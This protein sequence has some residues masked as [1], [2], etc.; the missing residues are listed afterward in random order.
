MRA[1]LALLA[2]GVLLLVA[3]AAP[4]TAVARGFLPGAEGFEVAVTKAGGVAA[5]AAGSH[6]YALEATVALNSSP[7]ALRELEISL[8]PGFLINPGAVSECTD[9]A[10]HTARSTQKPGSLSG[11]SC[12]NTTQVGVIRV[13]VGGTV[14]YFGLFNLV[15]PFGSPL[16]I[17]A[18]P[19]GTP[20]VFAGRLR[21]DDYGLD[22]VLRD[23][24]SSFDL[25]SMQLTIWG[26]PWWGQSRPSESHDPQ[27]GNCLDEES[28]GSLAGNCQ[29][30]GAGVQAPAQL[31][32]SYLTLPT[33]P[34]GQPLAF[35]ARTLSWQGQSDS[36]ADTTPALGA[37][38][39][40]LTTPKVRLTT[41]AAAARTG[42]AFDLDV[43]D[44][45]GILNPDGIARPPLKQAIVSLPEGLTINPS[46]GAGL[47]VCSEAE[48]AREKAG[49]EPGAGCPSTS[50]IGTVALDG[51][52]GLSEPLKGSLYLARPRA[53]PFGALIAVYMLARSPRRGL[54]VKSRG[55][56]EPD[57][58]RG[59]L[60]A[61]FDDLPRLLYTH[62][63]LGLRE[64]QRSALVSP[65]ACGAYP[66]GLD[67]SSWA[68]PTV[69]SHRTS[70]FLIDRG[71][72]GGGCPS[73]VPRFAPK[74][75]AGSIGATA[76]AY[77]PFYLRM[78]R[79]DGEQEITAYSASFPPGLLGKLAGVTTCADQAIAAAA[80]RSGA[81]EQANPSCPA[82]SSI[83]RTV[84][85]YGVGGTLAW[86]PGGLY[87]AGPY[88]G[89]PLSIV[90]IDAAVIGPFD[91]GTVVVRQAIR[92]DRRSA[93]VS[94]D[95][96]G[97][98]PIPHVLAGI[99]LHLRDIRVYVDRPGFMVN[100]TSCD[101]MQIGSTLGGAGADPFDP[102]DDASASSSQR[103]QVLNCSALG[104]KP[105]LGLRL[106]GPTR[107]GG[108]PSLRAVYRP[109]PKDANLSG[110]SVT[111]PPSLFLAQEHIA[112]VCT[113]VQFSA[114][115]CPAGAVYGHAQAVTPLLD[116]PLRGPVYLRSSRTAVPD[117][118]ADLRGR[119]IEIEV[120]ARIDTA[121]GGIRANFEALPDAP[122]AS[123][124]MTLFGGRRGL[125]A[126]AEAP[127]RGV[128]RANARF[129]AQSNETAVARPRLRA[130]CGGRHGRR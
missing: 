27:R 79:A 80:R 92:I 83:G 117:L 45:G 81:E 124:T 67:V 97:S 46:L 101:P 102:G 110:V 72:G 2:I 12:P 8:P 7:G 64:G 126:N 113:K 89:A 66:A 32:K 36:A 4:S 121:R 75:L 78:S 17:G 57:V 104:F 41:T 98:D 60:V 9:T 129:V 112:K 100:P 63:G 1:R 73:G 108:Y 50:K 40:P 14:R 26:T 59:R 42:L 109:R 39:K 43:N 16:A 58:L 53:N 25:R 87:L 11:E 107:H 84:A 116:E 103:Y 65:P 99:P 37:C 29:V 111:L 123:F 95:A 70:V 122:V 115:S 61:T 119:G 69:Y 19:F 127:C 15:P 96:A 13:D 10:F 88:H 118:V 18:S 86:A 125:L 94:L 38:N 85:G 28:G 31:V 74:V 128:H 120:P 22:L 93:R 82:S 24:P 68:E 105:R 51:A 34:C 76:G 52:L 21:E 77:S 6:P 33:T 5:T 44:G 106:R 30:F 20:L 3:T 114:G 47:A 49:S 62:F 54:I 23:A 48:F 130:R 56:I 35:A 91:L 71:D 55:K 90:A